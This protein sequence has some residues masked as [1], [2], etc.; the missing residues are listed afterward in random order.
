MQLL[1]L[2][3]PRLIT[4]VKKYYKYIIY[5]CIFLVLVFI[6]MLI[7]HNY[8]EKNRKTGYDTKI[9]N[10]KTMASH[11]ALEIVDETIYKDTIDNIVEVYS[12]K[13]RITV[14]YDLE[15]MQYRFDGDTLVV[16]L[17]KEN[18]EAYQLDRRLLDEYFADN[19]LRLKSPNITAEQSSEIEK[20]MKVFITTS[21]VNQ[22]HIKRARSNEL[23]NMVRLLKAIHPNVKVVMNINQPDTSI[24]PDS[25]PTPLDL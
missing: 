2:F 19:K 5:A 24:T 25:I 1:D 22:D 11:N 15:K 9:E 12:V 16:E 17:P 3:T 14:Q 10:V 4:F 18:I 20:R 21:M 7:Y 6:A 13:A 23:S 8:C